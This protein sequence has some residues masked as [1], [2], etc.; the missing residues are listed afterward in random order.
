MANILLMAQVSPPG[1]V[2]DLID[3]AIH[4]NSRTRSHLEPKLLTPHRAEV[5]AIHT[6][7]NTEHAPEVLVKS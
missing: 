2:R 4:R 7:A 6:L 3:H 5:T 1:F